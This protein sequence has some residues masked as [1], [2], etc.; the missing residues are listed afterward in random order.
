MAVG[1]HDTEL[2]GAHNPSAQPP[3][4]N[5]TRGLDLFTPPDEVVQNANIMTY[6]KSKGFNNYEAF[7]QWSLANRFVF[8]DD[9]T[10]ELHWYE[11]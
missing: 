9:M 10:K 2:S 6:M 1:E 7:Y 4:Q 5:I 3:S 11:P 8:W